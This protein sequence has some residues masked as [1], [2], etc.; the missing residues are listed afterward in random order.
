MCIRIY[1]LSVRTY[2]MDDLFNN[3]AFKARLPPSRHIIT[4]KQNQGKRC[5]RHVGVTK[6]TTHILLDIIQIIIEKVFISRQLFL[7]GRIKFML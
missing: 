3:Y 5:S 7:I 6:N 4:T 1:L 2:I